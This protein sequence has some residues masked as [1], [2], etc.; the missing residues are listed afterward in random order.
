VTGF[1][2]DE[3]MLALLAGDHG[4]DIELAPDGVFVVQR[5]DGGWR[6]AYRWDGQLWV[7]L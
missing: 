2:S 4:L 7:N 3:L 6:R 1:V 5:V